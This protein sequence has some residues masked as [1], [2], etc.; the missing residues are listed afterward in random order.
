MRPVCP[1]AT[2]GKPLAPVVH[3]AEASHLQ[4][5]Q[6]TS[7][8]ALL[9]ILPLPHTSST[10]RPSRPSR[11]SLCSATTCEYRVQ[12]HLG[13]PKTWYH[14]QVERQGR[15]RLSLVVG[16]IARD[17]TSGD[18]SCSKACNNGTCG[19]PSKNIGIT[20][21]YSWGSVGIVLNN[22]S[23]YGRFQKTRKLLPSRT[24]THSWNPNRRYRTLKRKGYVP[25]KS[26]WTWKRYGPGVPRKDCLSPRKH[27]RSS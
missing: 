20:R 4:P 1:V 26:R 5:W 13:H 7:L 22:G 27:G 3:V 19:E 16:I 18:G 14:S 2:S 10:Y 12:G 8:T 9:R 6:V 15:R 23:V 21:H 25:S 17:M 24:K 11:P